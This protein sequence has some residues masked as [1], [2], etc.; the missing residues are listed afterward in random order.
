M[1]PAVSAFQDNV[2]F[3]FSELHRG[4]GGFVVQEYADKMYRNW[5]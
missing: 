5:K 2:L 4:K 1:Y 3:V